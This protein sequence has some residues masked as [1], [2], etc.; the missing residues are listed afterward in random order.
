M[1]QLL[2]LMILFITGCNGK[3]EKNLS[4]R[5]RISTLIENKKK[6]SYYRL[7][8]DNLYI[9]ENKNLY[10]KSID[11][12]SDNNPKD[13]YISNIF[14]PK[15]GKKIP[16]NKIIDTI[17][18]EQ[19]KNSNYSKDKNNIYFLRKTLEGGYFNLIGSAKLGNFE[20]ITIDNVPYGKLGNKYFYNGEIV[21]HP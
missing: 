9:D 15:K 10:I 19:L 11:N 13:I 6:L 3:L 5:S 2:I 18:Y 17:T 4:T 20:L 8:K 14:I 16:L 7:I 12:T 21:K 1:K